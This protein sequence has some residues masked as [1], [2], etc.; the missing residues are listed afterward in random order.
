MTKRGILVDLEMC[1]GCWTCA[2]VCH[3][4]HHLEE[5]DYRLYIRTNGAGGVD[6]PAGEFPNCTIS[7][8]PIFTKSCTLCADRL[9]GGIEPYCMRNCPVRAIIHGDFD[10]ESSEI[11]Q[12]YQELLARGY[13]ADRPHAWEGVRPEVVYMTKGE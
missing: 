13:H 11:S 12:R 3:V 4:A 10:D 8:Q 7:W 6:E 5:D 1:S 9:A 2:M